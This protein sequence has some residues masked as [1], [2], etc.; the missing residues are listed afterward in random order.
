MKLNGEKLT[1]EIDTDGIDSATLTAGKFLHGQ[2]IEMT[3]LQVFTRPGLTERAT[4][5]IKVVN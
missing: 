4:H 2:A 5:S 1:R 3:L